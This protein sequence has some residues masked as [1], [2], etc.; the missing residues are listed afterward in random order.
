M[1]SKHFFYGIFF[2]LGFFIAI[3][4]GDQVNHHFGKAKTEVASF[5][6]KHHLMERA[7]RLGKKAKNSVSRFTKYMKSKTNSLNKEKDVKKNTE[8]KTSKSNLPKTFYAYGTDN[9]D[10]TE[11]ASCTLLD[12]K[13][14]NGKLVS[15]KLHCNG[16][17]HLRKQLTKRI[18]EKVS[19]G[20]L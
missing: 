11:N 16:R 13:I 5:A 17:T 20:E 10:P 2:I 15:T 18:N 6:K 3:E 1:K 7:K 14:K 4:Y 19:R 12:Y 8:V 9:Y